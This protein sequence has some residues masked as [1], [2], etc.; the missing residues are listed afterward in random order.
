MLKIFRDMPDRNVSSLHVVYH[1]AAELFSKLEAVRPA[2]PLR[3]G[4]RP[5]HWH[6]R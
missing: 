3:P 6:W 2:P 1:K 4:A 5:R